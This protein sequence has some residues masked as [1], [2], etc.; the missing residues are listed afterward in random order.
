VNGDVGPAVVLDAD[1]VGAIPDT[2][3]NADGSTR[4]PYYLANSGVQGVV[5]MDI[6]PTSGTVPKRQ[7]SGHILVPND[8]TFGS[9]ATNKN[10]VDG[11]TT[12]L[13][14][15]LDALEAAGFIQGDGS[16]TDLVAKTQAEY[17]AL[18]PDPTTHYLIDG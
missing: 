13:D 8:P 10:Y 7:A 18:T 11:L 16:V 6:N 4:I 3:A 15:R 17:D 5:I 9:Q 2:Y 1:D 14:E 12:A